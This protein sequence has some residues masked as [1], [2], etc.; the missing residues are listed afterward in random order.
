[1]LQLFVKGVTR[2][3]SAFTCS[4]STIKTPERHQWLRSGVLTLNRFHTSCRCFYCWLW[5][6]TCRLDLIPRVIKCNSF[7]KRKWIE[8]SYCSGNNIWAFKQ[9]SHYPIMVG[10][11]NHVLGCWVSQTSWGELSPNDMELV[12]NIHFCE[13]WVSSSNSRK[14]WIKKLH[15]QVFNRW[16]LFDAKFQSNGPWPYYISQCRRKLWY[17]LKTRNE[18]IMWT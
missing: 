10:L 14:Y 2:T 11:S 8:C 3:Q 6:S 5:A 9:F 7:R 17:N 12:Q 1:M 4:K 16:G 18:L 15:S 13:L